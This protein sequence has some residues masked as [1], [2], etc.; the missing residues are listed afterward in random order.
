MAA[1][2]PLRCFT[3]EL[4][5]K[6]GNGQRLSMN[7]EIE[8]ITTKASLPMQPAQLTPSLFDPC[9]QLKQHI[10]IKKSNTDKEIVM[11]H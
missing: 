11:K 6:L 5:G 1:T 8:V 9:A 10:Y 4:R 3:E 7:Y 2:N